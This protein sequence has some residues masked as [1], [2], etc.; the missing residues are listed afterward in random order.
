VAPLLVTEQRCHDH[1]LVRAGLVGQL[2]QLV[3]NLTPGPQ[4]VGA[5]VPSQLI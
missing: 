1:H 5:Q 2:C 4:D 3:D